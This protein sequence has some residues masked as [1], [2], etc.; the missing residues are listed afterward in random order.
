MHI[1]PRKNGSSVFLNTIFSN[2]L[3]Y[4]VTFIIALQSATCFYLTVLYLDDI[5]GSL[6]W[7]FWWKTYLDFKE[8]EKNV[9]NKGD[10]PFFA[11]IWTQMYTHVAFAQNNCTCFVIHSNVVF[12][13]AF[14]LVKRNHEIISKLILSVTH[15]NKKKC[16]K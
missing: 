5:K 14:L 9:R 2:N 11:F 8:I 6:N 3:P 15:K 10:R 12:L 13:Y 16:M 7:K 4:D 1:F